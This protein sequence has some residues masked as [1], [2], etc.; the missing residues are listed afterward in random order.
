MRSQLV[1]QCAQLIADFVMPPCCPIT[2]RPMA[3]A[4]SHSRHD[5]DGTSAR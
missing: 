4:T 1:R 3:F 5:D 2:R